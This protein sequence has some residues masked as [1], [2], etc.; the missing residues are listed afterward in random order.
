[1]RKFILLITLFCFSIALA[2]AP[3]DE[4]K[5]QF[6]AGVEADKAG[7]TDAAIAAY[8]AALKASPGYADAHRNLAAAYQAKK[9]FAKALPHLEAVTDQ[10]NADNLYD[11]GSLALQAKDN[12]KAVAIFEK[13]NA[14]K[15]NDSKLMM[16]LADAYKKD[17][18]TTKAIETYK[19]VIA[20]DAKNAT[21]RFN[22]GKIYFDDEEY[23]PAQGV[24]KQ[25]QTNFPND[26]RGYYMYALSVHAEDPENVEG[27]QPL[28][29]D[30]I[31]R[32]KGNGKAT[33]NVKAAEKVIDEI[34]NPKKK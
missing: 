1:M 31:K 25:M 32:F 7:K 30:F 16:A 24:F 23:V 12:V 17:R 20:A 14:A 9:E 6:N 27:Y 21:A 3:S 33:S 5:K 28:Y 11:L 15:P 13:A 29:E 18:Q 34:K 2:Q 10:K 4:A 26:H 8:E 19:K 22:L